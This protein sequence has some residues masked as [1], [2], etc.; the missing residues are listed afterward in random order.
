MW[1]QIENVDNNLD[2]GSGASMCL[3]T[4]R[5]F[6]TLSFFAPLQ[7]ENYWELKPAV[8][9]RPYPEKKTQA[10]RVEW[11]GQ[12]TRMRVNWKR[13][14][15]AQGIEKMMV[16]NRPDEIELDEVAYTDKMSL[17]DF[18]LAC[19]ERNLRYSWSKGRL[20]DGLLAFKINIGNKLKLSIANKLFQEQRRKPIT[21]GQPKLPSMKEQEAH[22][23]T[24]ISY[25]P[26]CQAC[27]ASRAKED[28]HE[29]REE[30]VDMGKNVIQ[31][32]LFFAYTGEGRRLD[33]RP[34]DKV[35]EMSD[36]FG[37]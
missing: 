10:P 1:R 35:T 24:H 9:S 26:W 7:M 30:K 32:D 23:V 34:P 22:F 29:S 11:S 3:G 20:L 33:E 14:A 12:R 18:Q 13:N 28:K 17:K 25:A 5:A 27:V 31:L 36:Q 37:T 6:R 16:A 21:L 15:G 8:P 19:K 4:G 2:P